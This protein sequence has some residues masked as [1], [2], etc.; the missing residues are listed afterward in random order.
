MHL[1]MWIWIE[2]PSFPLAI[3]YDVDTLERSHV[4]AFPNSPLSCLVDGEAKG[5]WKMGGRIA[6]YLTDLFFSRA[7]KNSCHDLQFCASLLWSKR[8]SH[9]SVKVFYL[10][11][12]SV[13]RWKPIR[14]GGPSLPIATSL[15]AILYERKA[16]LSFLKK[17]SRFTV[18][19]LRP[20][21]LLVS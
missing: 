17:H 16:V 1:N 6:I 12:D 2:V 7:Q 11:D 20:C 18:S 10:M 4:D 3:G 15:V 19:S 13:E 21:F 9:I 8:C 14:K 5:V